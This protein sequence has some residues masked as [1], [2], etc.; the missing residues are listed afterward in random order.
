MLLIATL[1]WVPASD[2][3]HKTKDA[4]PPVR[5]SQ[6]PMCTLLTDKLGFGPPGEIYLGEHYSFV[7]LDFLDEDRVLFTFRV[8][9]LYHRDP[10]KSPDETERHIRAVVLHIPDGA[11]ESEAMWTVHDYGRYLYMLDGGQFVLRDRDTL[12]LGDDSLRV[13]PW[14]HFPGP[15]AWVELDPTRQFL[16]T[17]SH[18]T[19]SEPQ[20]SG[21]VA[22][23]P[24]AEGD[25]TSGDI[26][27][28]QESGSKSDLILRILRRSSGQVM[29]FSR[30]RSLVHLPVNGEGYL[31]PLRSSGIQWLL[32]LDSFTGGSTR[33]GAIDSSCVPGFDFLSTH[34]FVVSAC[35]NSG[36]R[37]IV[38]MTTDGRH[39]WHFVDSDTSV[40]PMMTPSQSGLRLAREILRANHPVNA[41]APVDAEDI[42]RQE[43]AVF[44]AATGKV[45]LHAL[46][47]PVYDGGGNVALS[48]SG[49]RVAIIMDGE[50]QIFEL[51]DAPEL[52]APKP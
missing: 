17:S 49:R 15:L 32:N 2:A 4:P 11:V 46:A 7:S 38:A 18:E 30:I 5:A 24:T 37:G 9:G 43:V 51:P 41:H 16:V 20:K 33:V 47:S 1:L 25:V 34:E 50:V 3:K 36:A 8:P 13:K 39:L 28:R 40:W 22:S 42:E 19:S 27:I 14:L 52:P 6:Q 12:S 35:S 44:D 26:S 21:D 29:L 45:A 23:L 31:E 10:N 48:P